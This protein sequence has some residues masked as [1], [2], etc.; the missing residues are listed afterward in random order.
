MPEPT[1]YAAGIALVIASVATF[2]YLREASKEYL[3]ERRES[4]YD[5][6]KMLLS[7]TSSYKDFFTGYETIH[8]EY[9]KASENA[10][11]YRKLASAFLVSGI[12]IVIF[13]F[14]W[15]SLVL[16]LGVGVSVFLGIVTAL[17]IW[18]SYLQGTWSGIQEVHRVKPKRFIFQRKKKSVKQPEEIELKSSTR[19]KQDFKNAIATEVHAILKMFIDQLPHSDITY[20]SWSSKAEQSKATILNTEDYVL[21]KTLYD[22]IEKRN[23]HLASKDWINTS[24]LHLVN[25][26]CVEALS[27]A[28]TEIAWIRGSADMDSLLSQAKKKVGLSENGSQSKSQKQVPTTPYRPPYAD[29]QK[30]EFV[31]N[32]MQWAI[33][34]AAQGSVGDAI[35]TMELAK[36]TGL[37]NA[38]VYRECVILRDTGYVVFTDDSHGMAMLKI[39][40]QGLLALRER[41][42]F[43]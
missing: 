43:T 20:P 3:E 38:D 12:A 34:E 40:G 37:D 33:L 32:N 41:T 8:D 14:F 39:T 5:A 4:T 30:T 36:T 6:I 17:A 28:I 23:Q 2:Y 26:K 25:R 1:I 24:E 21:L 9:T 15:D 35:S 16:A 7:S 22:A 31:F 19:E 11:S 27:A 10:E 13:N 29:P 42:R 18:S